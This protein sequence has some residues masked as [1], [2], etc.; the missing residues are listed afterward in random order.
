MDFQTFTD[1]GLKPEDPA[2]FWFWGFHGIYSL[3]LNGMLRSDFKL[4][5]YI[6]TGGNKYL[7][8][9][10]LDSLHVM[11]E[12]EVL[13][14]MQDVKLM[15]SYSERLGFPVTMEAL[16]RTFPYWRALEEGA[17]KSFDESLPKDKP[18]PYPGPH[19]HEVVG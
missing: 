6:V 13:G 16:T 19:W 17:G 12:P 9:S 5:N 15:M 10:D 11:S 1:R 8:V 2:L 18:V 4:E 3:H 14:M 7:K